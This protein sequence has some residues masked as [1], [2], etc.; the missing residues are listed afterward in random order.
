M[1][2]K[3]ITCPS[4]LKAKKGADFDCDIVYTDGTKATITLHQQDDKGHV[5]VRRSDLHVEAVV[6]PCTHRCCQ[7][8]GRSRRL[9]APL[10]LPRGAW[11]VSLKAASSRT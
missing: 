2:R 6:G 1:K 7:A 8:S 10:R 3:S 11:S 9:T 5:I 4:D